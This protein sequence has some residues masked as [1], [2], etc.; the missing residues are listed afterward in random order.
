MNDPRPTELVPL[1]EPKG[2]DRWLLQH[3]SNQ[4]IVWNH[5]DQLLVTDAMCPHKALPLLEGT[6][7][8][9]AIV[10]PEHWYAFEL[11]TGRCRTSIAAAQQYE[12]TLHPVEYVDGVAHARLPVGQPMTLVERLR[13]HARGAL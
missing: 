4:Y 8:H 2:R 7:R 11:G 10:C 5:D 3:H 13:A 1:G 6:I 12:L 9:G